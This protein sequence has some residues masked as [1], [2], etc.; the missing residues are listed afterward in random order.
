MAGVTG[1]V[2]LEKK[3]RQRPS[4]STAG[5]LGTTGRVTLTH[6]AGAGET[7]QC[8]GPA[9]CS[10]NPVGSDPGPLAPGS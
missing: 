2:V 9:G 7:H 6:L 8:Q 10:L 4:H 5:G 1:S 3:G